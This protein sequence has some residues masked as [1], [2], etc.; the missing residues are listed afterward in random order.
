MGGI[1]LFSCSL[2]PKVDGSEG[3]GTYSTTQG[4]RSTVPDLLVSDGDTG[5][6]LT[7]AYAGTYYRGVGYG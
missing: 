5:I 2:L 1:L 4:R 3:V 6:I 7:G